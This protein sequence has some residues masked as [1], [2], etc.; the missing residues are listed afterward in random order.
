MTVGAIS[1]IQQYSSSAQ[2]QFFST[3]VSSAKID[4]LMKLYGIQPTGDD[5]ADLKA[6]Y[7]A[8]YNYYSQYPDTSVNNQP[9]KPAQATQPWAPLMSQV[10]LSM[11]GSLQGDYSAFMNKIAQLQAAAGSPSQIASYKS[12][13]AQAQS[14]FVAPSQPRSSSSQMLGA[15]IIAQMNRSLVI[16][17]FK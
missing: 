17:K 13:E 9:S 15:D 10:G 3:A 4:E 1:G 12:L 6:L 11:T 8:M 7:Q 2:I 14:A 5:Y 16:N